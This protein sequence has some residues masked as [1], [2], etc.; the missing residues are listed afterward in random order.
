MSQAQA[1][2]MQTINESVQRDDITVESLSELDSGF[3]I[4]Y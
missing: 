3:H 4:C 1:N 2:V